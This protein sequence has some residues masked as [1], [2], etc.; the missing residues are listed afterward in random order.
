MAGTPATIALTAAG[1]AFTIHEYAHDASER[2]YGAEA[3]RELQLDPER[4][5]KTLLTLVDDELCVAV[6]PVSGTLDMK[7]LAAARGARKA[8]MAPIDLAQRS[9]GYLI[10]GISPIGQR[11]ALPTVVDETIVLF[12]TVFVSGGKRGLDLGLAPN[13]LIIVTGAMTAAIARGAQ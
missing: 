5:F 4:V 2:K 3:A 1:I 9:T 7:A 11:R 12:D 6:V 10:G 13:D 8:E